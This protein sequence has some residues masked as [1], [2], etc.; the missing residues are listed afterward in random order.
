LHSI[1]VGE[2]RAATNDARYDVYAVR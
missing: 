2:Y 1:G